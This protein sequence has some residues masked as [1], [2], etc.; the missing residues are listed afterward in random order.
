MQLC[1]KRACCIQ[2]GWGMDQEAS[3]E[4]KGVRRLFRGDRSLCTSI[5]LHSFLL[6]AL[7]QPSPP[8]PCLHHNWPSRCSRSISMVEALPPLAAFCNSGILFLCHKFF[9]ATSQSGIQLGCSRCLTPGNN[10]VSG[11]EN[12]VPKVGEF[13]T[14]VEE[15]GLVFRSATDSTGRA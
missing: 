1:Q 2:K 11:L 6:P 10:P 14:G 12:G 5:H 3:E 7:F 13:Y 4:K 9:H 8:S 15:L